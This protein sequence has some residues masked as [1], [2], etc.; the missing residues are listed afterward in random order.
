MGWTLEDNESV[1]ALISET[2][3][4]IYERYRMLR[5]SMQILLDIE[6]NGVGISV[7]LLV[8][9][10]LLTGSRRAAPT[11]YTLRCSP[12]AGVHTHSERLPFCTGCRP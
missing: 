1:N 10:I 8:V 4:R 11:A 9:V 12:M 5:Q 2:G 6:S 7:C 3:T